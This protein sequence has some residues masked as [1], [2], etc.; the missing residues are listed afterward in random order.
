MR[1]DAGRGTRTQSI[2]KARCGYGVSLV[3][4][5]QCQA[6]TTLGIARSTSCLF[7]SLS[8]SLSIVA[9]TNCATTNGPCERGWS[10]RHARLRRGKPCALVA[11]SPLS[12]PRWLA[13]PKPPGF[14]SAVFWGP[15]ALA[16][17]GYER[18]RPPCTPPWTP[19]W[20]PA[21]HTAAGRRRLGRPSAAAA[22]A[23]VLEH[24]GLSCAMP[25]PPARSASSAALEAV[26]PPPQ[27]ARTATTAESA[28]STS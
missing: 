14:L 10:P 2:W 12:R 19:P 13:A 25:P 1:Q 11:P 7:P 24:G 15:W 4:G 28:A 21:P 9:T 23:L 18:I 16:G 27:A 6:C 3:H 20:T 22:I 8:L 26:A 5:A 17:A